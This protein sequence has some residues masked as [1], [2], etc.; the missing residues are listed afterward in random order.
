MPCLMPMV[1]LTLLQQIKFLDKQ[2]PLPESMVY[3]KIQNHLHQN[4]TGY[5]LQ[6]KL[7]DN[8]RFATSIIGSYD[9]RE[10]QYNVTLETED[11][12]RHQKAY[13]LSYTEARK[14]WVS[15]KSFITQGGISH[16]NIYYTFP[17]N[18]YSLK[19]NLDPWGVSYY[20]TDQSGVA[21]AWQHNLDIRV[22]RQVVGNPAV[23]SNSLVV[24]DNSRGA[25]LVGMNVIGNG[26][27]I[28]T[29]VASVAC[30]GSTCSIT[31][32]KNCSIQ[33]ATF[34]VTGHIV[35]TSPRNS[36]Y[37]IKDHYSMVKVL[38]NKDQGSVKTFK[39]LDYEGS[40]ARTIFRPNNTHQI[41]G[42]NVG[43]VYYDNIEKLGWFAYH[44]NTD[45]QVGKVH[46]FKDKENK[47]YNFIRGYGTVL[48]NDS[49]DLQPAGDG[50]FNH[51]NFGIAAS[52]HDQLDT[53]AFSLQGLG[54]ASAIGGKDSKWGCING[55]CREDVNGVYDTK[56]KCINSNCEE[57]VG[58]LD[59]K[60]N[61]YDANATLGD[62]SCTYDGCT[63]PLADNY[64]PIN[65]VDDGSCTYAV[66]YDCDCNNVGDCYDP[67][68]G[69]GEFTDITACRDACLAN[70]VPGCTS[71]DACN[72]DPTANCDD[73]SCEFGSFPG[74]TDSAF[75]NYDPNADCDDGSCAN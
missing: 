37:S 64:D 25:I 24:T 35:F 10:D 47:W 61:N 59:P 74:C 32:D 66:T 45:M 56:M 6:I 65:S 60:A 36:F 68:D 21:E 5:I 16:K 67:G 48:N 26:V 53:G 69:T 11:I 8:L 3:Q 44:L 30:N 70:S 42:I 73:G 75:N 33:S 12:D 4:L 51:D 27:P 58:C 72:Y 2:Y 22:S 46:E 40:Q 55:L 49:Y 43:Q 54:F 57:I 13:T 9:D 52:Q 7:E 39:T 1:T 28:D 71:R 31:L 50:I 62:N 19:Q 14:G 15:F 34:G 38:F 17:S 20:L 41:E 63:D 29:L 18:S 23:N